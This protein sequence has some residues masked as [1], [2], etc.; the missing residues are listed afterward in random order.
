[1]NLIE[2]KLFKLTKIQIQKIY[3]ILKI[4]KYD[5]N[6]S[7]KNLITNLLKPLKMKYRIG[8]ETGAGSQNTVRNIFLKKYPQCKTMEVVEIELPSHGVIVKRTVRVNEEDVTMQIRLENNKLGQFDVLETSDFV[9]TAL[10]N[11]TQDQQRTGVNTGTG[12]F[13]AF[14]HDV[15]ADGS[16]YVRRPTLYWYKTFAVVGQWGDIIKVQSKKQ[17]KRPVSQA[18]VSQAPVQKSI[19]NRSITPI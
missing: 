12:N 19:I 6:N 2:K 16:L 5:K 3:Q 10:Y 18:P 17:A 4:N 13:S 11:G 1:M 8:I 7:K 9:V 15:L 14:I